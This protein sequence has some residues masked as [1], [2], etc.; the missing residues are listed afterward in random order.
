MQRYGTK[1]QEGS[2]SVRRIAEKTNMW[3]SNE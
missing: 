1:K 3:E 2:K